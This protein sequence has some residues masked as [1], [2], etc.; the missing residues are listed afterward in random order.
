MTMFY[1]AQF[2]GESAWPAVVL[3]VWD[4]LIIHTSV[5]CNHTRFFK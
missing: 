4:T 2:W 1:S 3:K 5:A